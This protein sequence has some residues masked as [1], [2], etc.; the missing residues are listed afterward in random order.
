[1]NS[2]GYRCGATLLHRFDVRFKFFLL[3]LLSLVILKAGLLHLALLIGA[4]IVLFAT[5]GLSFRSV[6]TTLR[7]VFVLF[8]LVFTVRVFTTPGEALIHTPW[9]SVSGQ[10]L[11]AGA[12]ITARMLL[13]VLL[14]LTLVITT[15]PAEIKAAVEWFLKPLPG[16]PRARIGTMLGLLV[17]LIPLL[18][19][20]AEETLDAQRARGIEN[21]KN[22]VYRLTW[23]AIP[24]LRRSFA[25]VDRLSTAMEARCY[26]DDRT[27]YPLAAA[28]RDWLLLAAGMAYGVFVL[29]V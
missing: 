27:G 11:A 8:A 4:N 20:Q 10:G 28:R 24:F 19:A 6:W 3:I 9:L 13:V 25:A 16:I 29:V 21:R 2:I 12:T 5:L 18:A 1:V 22:P 23:F 7:Y 17:R 14:G 26:S 15:R